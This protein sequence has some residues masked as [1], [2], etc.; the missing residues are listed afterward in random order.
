VGPAHVMSP[1]DKVIKV[2]RSTGRQEGMVNGAV[3]QTWS[4]G[5]EVIEIGVI[6]EG[7]FADKG[8]SGALCLHENANG[9]FLAAGLIVGTHMETHLATV[10]PMWVLLE[11][12]SKELGESVELWEKG[13]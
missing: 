4:D 3:I 9:D 1:G 13:E 11:D 7:V 2:G 12:I 10:T 5:Q 6:G 8:D